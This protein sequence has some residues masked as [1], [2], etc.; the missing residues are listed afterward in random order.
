MLGL[1]ALLVES[2]TPRPDA[3]HSG[4]S[5]TPIRSSLILGPGLT[6]TEQN[7]TF[8]FE[9]ASLSTFQSEKSSVSSTGLLPRPCCCWIQRRSA[10]LR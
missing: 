3:A 5:G 2:Q 9:K 7:Q 10:L 1:Y 8:Q 4:E 6:M